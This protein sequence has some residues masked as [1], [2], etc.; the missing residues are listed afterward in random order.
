MQMIGVIKTVVT[1]ISLSINGVLD[2]RERRISLLV[3]AGYGILGLIFVIWDG[4]ALKGL[5]LSLIPGALC[6]VLAWL[7]R[8]RV[9]YGDGLLLLAIG[10][11]LSCDDMVLLCMTAIIGAGICALILLAFFHKGKNYE[12]PFIPFVFL[13]YLVAGGSI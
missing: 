1:I 2:I 7:S 13:G 3:T 12:I 6:L 10:F 5:C 8:E 9:G 11:Y 4:N